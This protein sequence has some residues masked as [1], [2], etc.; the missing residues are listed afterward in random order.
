MVIIQ[1]RQLVL[2][3]LLEHTKS[4]P[5]LKIPRDHHVVVS[6]RNKLKVGDRVDLNGIPSYQV[7][8]RSPKTFRSCNTGHNEAARHQEALIGFFDFP[9]WRGM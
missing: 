7:P 6:D 3:S 8:L 2:F 9:L 5:R 4:N 1:H